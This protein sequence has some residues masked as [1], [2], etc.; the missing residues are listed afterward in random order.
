MD[1]ISQED[2]E[3]WIQDYIAE[4]NE[5]NKKINE[6][7]HSTKY[8]KW[9]IQF[10]KDKEGFA[11]DD[12]LYFPEEISE[13]DRKN[14]ELLNLFYRGIEK[15]AQQNY[16]YPKSR[17]YC[18]YYKIKLG[19]YGFEIG[20]LV[21]QGAAFFCNKAPIDNAKD[22]INFKDIMIGKKQEN[23][24]QINIKLDS[25][26]EMVI[27]AYESGVPVEAIIETF[28]NAIENITTRKNK[29]RRLT[30]EE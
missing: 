15:Y 13:S 5:N 7:M 30:K 21:G 27:D 1:N 24:Y 10:T 8:I 9:L 26:A 4:Q 11:D 14:V 22:F 25:L 19:E 23:V 12:W 6:M 28:D 18:N 20:V 2:K 29:T 16:I 3:K 17:D